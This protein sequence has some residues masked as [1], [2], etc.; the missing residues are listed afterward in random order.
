MQTSAQLSE[1]NCFQMVA[2][3]SLKGQKDV[4]NI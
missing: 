3:E 1:L 4:F 2:Y